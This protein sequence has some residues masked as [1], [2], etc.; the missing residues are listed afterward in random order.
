MVSQLKG[1]HLSDDYR[2]HGSSQPT[3]RE[4]ELDE[5]IKSKLDSEGCLP[6]LVVCDEIR[7][8]HGS[9]DPAL[10]AALLDKYRKPSTAL[11]LWQPPS[12]DAQRAISVPIQSTSDVE[13][14]EDDDNN[15][16]SADNHMNGQ[17][18]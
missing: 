11:V 3:P 13:M 8:L 17:S 4:A 15:N 2:P 12:R 9:L 16:S 14:G 1:I 18:I 5:C 7:A 10:P 6:S